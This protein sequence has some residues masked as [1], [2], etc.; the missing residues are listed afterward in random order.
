MEARPLDTTEGIRAEL[1]HRA[2]QERAAA[3]IGRTNKQRTAEAEHAAR[4]LEH[5]AA[6]IER[7]NVS[8]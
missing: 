8:K 1:I 7:A 4:A 3:S 2:W 5:L 6:G